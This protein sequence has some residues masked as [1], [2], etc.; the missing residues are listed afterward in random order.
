M[1]RIVLE[2]GLIIF[3]KGFFILYFFMIQ[4]N[5][6]PVFFRFIDLL[7]ECKAGYELPVRQERVEVGTAVGNL[8]G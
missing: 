2:Y 5:Y 6:I 8:S 3:Y 7:A 1:A 4:W